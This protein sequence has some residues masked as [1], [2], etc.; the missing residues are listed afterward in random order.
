MSATGDPADA[1]GIGNRLA[2]EML[3]DGAARLTDTA[4]KRQNA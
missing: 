3:A 1:E 4:D 2:S